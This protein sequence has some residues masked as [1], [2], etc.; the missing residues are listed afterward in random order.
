MA[1]R[2][3]KAEL[4]NEHRSKILYNINKEEKQRVYTDLTKV[5]NKEKQTRR[6]ADCIKRVQERDNNYYKV[7]QNC[8]EVQ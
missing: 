4:K 2:L 6:L 1:S 3:P 7:L 8:K 5:L